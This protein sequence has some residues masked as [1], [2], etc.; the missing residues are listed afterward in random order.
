MFFSHCL[1]CN[2]LTTM[3]RPNFENPIDTAREIVER[4]LTVLMWP[5]GHI[6]IQFLAQSPIEDYQRL[7]DRMY[8]TKDNAEQYFLA[9]QGVINAGTHVRMTAYLTP[10]YLEFGKWYR[11]RETVSGRN[12]YVGYLSNK[13]WNLNEEQFRNF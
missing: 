4:N 1:L 10:K 8:V 6:W 11:S 9:E 2:I 3:L 5:N 13:N 7:S 12:P